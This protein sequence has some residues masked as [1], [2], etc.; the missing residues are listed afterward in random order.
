MSYIGP[1]TKNIV[2]ACVNEF[3]KKETKDRVMKNLID[4]VIIELFKRYSPYIASFI[5]IHIVIIFLLIYI[6]YIVKKILI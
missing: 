2:D 3:K 5:L 6:I 1:L 4:P